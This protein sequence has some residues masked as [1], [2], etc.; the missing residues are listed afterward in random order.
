M[1]LFAPPHD[2]LEGVT[3]DYLDSRN[4]NL[5]DR[6]QPMTDWL[7]ARLAQGLDPYC[8]A[9]SGRI[10][11]R[12]QGTDR[13]GRPI[14]GL[15]FAAQDYLS[16]SSHHAVIAAVHDAAE[17]F[18]VH[19]AGSAA[20]MGLSRL[21]L[22]LEATVARFTGLADATVFPTGWGA[23]Y[24]AI[25]ALV[26]PDDHAVI[27]MMAHNCLLEAAAAAT[28]NVHRFPHAST[29]GAARRL[30]RLR[31]DFP[32][33]GILLVTEGLFS[34]EADTPDLAALQALARRYGATLL[35]D[36]AHDLGSSGPQGRGALGMQGLHGQADVVMGSFSKTFAGNGGFVASNHPALKLALR[37]MTGPQTFTNAMS[38]VQAAAVQAAFAIVASPE[39]AARRQ[40]LAANISHLRNGLAQAGFEVFGQPS[41]IVPVR[42]GRN[43][44]AR[45]LTAAVLATGGIVNLVE[46]PAVPRNACRW[47]LQVMAD[48]D[49]ADIDEFV[50]L[51]S[52]A[53]AGL[54]MPPP[55]TPPDP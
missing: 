51:A 33:A 3:T 45:R 9:N 4:P 46:Y 41:P 15:N 40:K 44:T 37:L 42:I 34:M 16:L 11:P 2:V 52:A 24:S 7:A 17:R 10:G 21:T 27:D 22:E 19:S 31:R 29:D 30:E 50:A 49:S 47:R 53:R 48:H 23:G 38:P 54:S 6:W 43:A 14:V 28:Q 26:R 1:T 13:A 5:L 35:V 12:V 36:V 39:G 8:K 20:L 25:R 18:G 55:Q 32:Q